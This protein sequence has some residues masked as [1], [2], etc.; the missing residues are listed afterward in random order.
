V[1]RFAAV[2]GA[3]DDLPEPAAGLRRVNAIRIGGRTLEVVHLPPAK[4]RAG[5]IPFLTLAV[6][7]EDER[8]LFRAD[9]DSD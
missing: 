6:G 5:D 4:L 8:A 1:P 7:R 3:L 2:I 9:E